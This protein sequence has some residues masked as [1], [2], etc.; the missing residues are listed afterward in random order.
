M[1]RLLMLVG[2]MM[3]LT[4]ALFSTAVAGHYG[5]GFMPIDSCAYIGESGKYRLTNNIDACVL[6]ALPF[7]PI[8]VIIDANNVVLDLNGHT[9]SCQEGGFGVLFASF[10]SQVKVKNGTVSGC[11]QGIVMVENTDS[12]VKKMTI[13]GN[14]LGIR[15]YGGFD[16]KISRNRIT[17]NFG[18]G[19][20]LDAFDLSGEI[21]VGSAGHKV[22]KNLIA[23]N[24]NFGI[25]TNSTED[26]VFAC[27]RTDWNLVGIGLS[28]FATG[29]TV[30]NNIAN[31]NWDGGI[32]AFGVIGLGPDVVPVA[33][34]NT[35]KHNSALSNGRVDLSEVTVDFTQGGALVA[36]PECLN[37][38]RKNQFVVQVGPL[39]CIGTT[40]VFDDDDGC[41]P[42]FDDDDDDRDDDD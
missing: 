34:G 14:G 21:F 23:Y 27:N 19:I 10:A 22:R 13:S 24:A 6:D 42:G 29:N 36:G 40:S 20:F 17:E 12:T 8:G 3:L 4:I 31:H 28:G 26:S 1:K 7:F 15:M 2:S 33:S 11:N 35:F 30:K 25:S 39:D 5:K 16:N 18:D 32:S 41:A 37:V 38:W 9:I